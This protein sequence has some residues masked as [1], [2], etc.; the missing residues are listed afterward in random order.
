MFQV[1]LNAWFSLVL[2]SVHCE[3]WRCAVHI[4]TGFLFIYLLTALSVIIIC[5][6]YV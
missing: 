1:M 2:L 5:N 4:G 6:S 3:L